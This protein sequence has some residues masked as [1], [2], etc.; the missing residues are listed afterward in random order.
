MTTD[1]QQKIT[2]YT[3]LFVL[4]VIIATVCIIGIYAFGKMTR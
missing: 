1:K 4:A 2:T 3:A